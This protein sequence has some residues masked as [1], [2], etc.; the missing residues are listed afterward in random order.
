MDAKIVKRKEILKNKE[1]NNRVEYFEATPEI[2]KSE[3]SESNGIVSGLLQH[4]KK[5]KSTNCHGMLLYE[6][7]GEGDG[8]IG[9][10]YDNE[11]WLGNFIEKRDSYINFFWTGT[12]PMKGIN[13]NNFSVKWEGFIKAPYTGEFIFSIESNN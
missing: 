10:Y 2:I 4:R 7:E 1:S 13:P 9:K 6:E 5:E 12:S 8:L 11:A 3:S